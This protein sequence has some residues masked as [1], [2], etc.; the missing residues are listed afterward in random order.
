MC[1][2]VRNCV[3][4]KKK[5]DYKM[6]KIQGK[7]GFQRYLLLRDCSM[8]MTWDK[9]NFGVTELEIITLLLKCPRCAQITGGARD[10][11]TN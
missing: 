7:E 10:G 2:F 9:S 8:P 5:I 1:E 11:V 6:E 4:V 3:V